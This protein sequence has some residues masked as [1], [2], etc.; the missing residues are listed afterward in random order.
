MARLYGRAGRLTAKNGGLRPGQLPDPLP[1]PAMSGG[2]LA[3]WRGWWDTLGR[4][5][6]TMEIWGR[7][8]RGHFVIMPPRISFVWRI[9][10]G[11]A[12]VSD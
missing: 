12:N 8:R 9:P 3:M 4:Y 1:T 6:E 5:D 11:T 2:L 7:L 10:I